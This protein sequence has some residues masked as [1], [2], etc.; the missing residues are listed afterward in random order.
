VSRP[1]PAKL[2]VNVVRCKIVEWDL[3]RRHSPEQIGGRLRV[4]YPDQPEIR[5]SIERVY[6][7]L[8]L[9]FSGALRRELARCLRTGRPLR[10]PY[11]KGGQ[12]K[13]GI[14]K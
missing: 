10:H 1:K 7:R 14:R 3:A 5:V 12:R 13:N 2:Q 11:R 9:Q 6:Q 8:H 4:R